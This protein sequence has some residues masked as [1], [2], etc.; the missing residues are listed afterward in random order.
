MTLNVNSIVRVTT[1]ITPQGL[2]RREFGIPLF[3]T[4]DTTLPAGAGRVGVFADFDGVAEVFDVGTEPYKAAN[5][6]FQ[7]NPFPKNLVIGRW[8]DT[9]VPAILDGGGTALLAAITAISDGS[10][11]IS[12]EDFLALDFSRA[13][14]LP[15]ESK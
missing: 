15:P 11:Q 8:V 1:S 4:T 5:I 7:Q 2:L 14:T 9:D 13:K 12:G 6:Y 10:L 3:L